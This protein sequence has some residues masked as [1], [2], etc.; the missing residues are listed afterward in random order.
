MIMKKEGHPTD[1][2]DPVCGMVVG[3]ESAASDVEYEGAHF[4]FCS[5]MCRTRFLENPERYTA[6]GAES[7]S[8]DS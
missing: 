1:Y 8:A 5:D 2:K 4:Y 6:K 7:R 3:R